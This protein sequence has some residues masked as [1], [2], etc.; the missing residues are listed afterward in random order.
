[1]KPDIIV[2]SNKTK[3]QLAPMACDLEGFALGHNIIWT[4][5][6]ASASIN[7]NCG[8]GQAKTEIVVMMDDDISG[9]YEGWIDGLIEPLIGDDDVVYVSANLVNR[10]GSLGP[11]MFRGNNDEK[12]TQVPRAPTACVAFRN[13]GI[14]FDERF[15]GSGFEDDDFCAKLEEKYDGGKFLVHNEV[16]IVHDNTEVNQHGKYFEHNQKLFNSIWETSG[17]VRKRRNQNVVA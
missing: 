10:D 11:M 7:R 16:R 17:N 15:I 14:R 2:V 4:C 3:L 13:D 12:W 5:Q 9:F 8:L 6:D 1:M